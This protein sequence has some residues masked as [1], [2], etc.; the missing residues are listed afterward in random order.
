M[1]RHIKHHYDRLQLWHKGI[2]GMFLVLGTLT[3]IFSSIFAA[4]LPFETELPTMFSGM[5]FNSGNFSELSFN[6]G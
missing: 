4:S 1:I 3:G 6:Y 5:S 2:L